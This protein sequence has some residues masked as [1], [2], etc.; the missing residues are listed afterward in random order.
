[1]TTRLAG[2]NTIWRGLRHN[3]SNLGNRLPGTAG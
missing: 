1:M 3:A 2:E